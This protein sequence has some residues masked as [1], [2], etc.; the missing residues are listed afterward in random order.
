[1]NEYQFLKLHACIVMQG[2][3]QAAGAR[4][5]RVQ[6]E[7]VSR[8]GRRLEARQ[9]KEVQNERRWHE[10]ILKLRDTV[11]MFVDFFECFLEF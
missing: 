10:T 11:E 4:R 1:M 5:G 3:A 6:R 8:Q 2:A 7:L 9:L